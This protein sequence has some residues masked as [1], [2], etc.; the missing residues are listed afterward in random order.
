[1]NKVD[2]LKKSRIYSGLDDADLILMASVAVDRSVKQ[3]EYVFWEGDASD[4]F[5][6]VVTGRVKV[7]KHSTSGKELIVAFFDAGEVFGEVA[8]FENK[9]YPAS[10]QAV[11]DVVLL[12]F[13]RDDFIRFL[14]ERPQIA[15][16]VINIL[17]ER[18]RVAQ[19]RISDLAGERV[20]QR[21]ARILLMLSSKLGNT[22]PFTR[23]EIADMAGMTTETV[24]RQMS[25]LKD[26]KIVT[27]TR[28]ETIIIDELK[29]KLLAEG[30]PSA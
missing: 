9:P 28:G 23:E 4:W 13:S 27:S 25:N 5:F 29:L 12:G 10:A 19:G 14:S 30:P 1:M 24:I 17:G 20:E 6:V 8:V 21:L 11:E 15:L 22:L 3:G 16:K 7:V 26:R 18:L 2:V